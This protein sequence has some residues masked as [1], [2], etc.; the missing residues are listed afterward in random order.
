[1]FYYDTKEHRNT[2]QSDNTRRLRLIVQVRLPRVSILSFM[3]FTIL[4]R[5]PC[6]TVVKALLKIDDNC[7]KTML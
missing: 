2:R 7:R 6:V 3:T 5:Y 4:G 1:M